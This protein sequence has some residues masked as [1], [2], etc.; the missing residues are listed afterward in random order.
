MIISNDDNFEIIRTSNEPCDK[1][2]AKNGIK[3]MTLLSS[4]QVDD[5]HDDT[6]NSTDNKIDRYHVLARTLVYIY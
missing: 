4:Q 6:K 2:R 3:R 5:T 1:K